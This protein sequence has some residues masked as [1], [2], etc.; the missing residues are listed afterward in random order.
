MSPARRPAEASSAAV[1]IDWQTV[2]QGGAGMRV[3]LSDDQ[4]AWIREG[5]RADRVLEAVKKV[6]G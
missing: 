5:L 4:I 3:T 6:V 2:L 1:K